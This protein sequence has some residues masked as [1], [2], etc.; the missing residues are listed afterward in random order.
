MKKNLLTVIIL[1]LLV[2]NIVLTSV[3]MFSVMG[4]NKKT[5]ELVS[6][7]AT[8]LNLE[9]TVPGQEEEEELIS[10]EDTA[11]FAL[12]SSMTILLAPEIDPATGEAS[13]KERYIMFNVSLLMNKEHKDYKKYGESIGE[14]ENVIKD[15]ISTTVSAHTESECRND[16]ESLKEEILEKIQET[17]QSD[18]IY[19]IAISDMKVG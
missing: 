12:S 8:V 2:V 17:F 6:N 13:T 14:K 1:A 19:K 15:I 7:I 16:F 5:A 10:M 9:L 3:L 11:E 18:F 4:T